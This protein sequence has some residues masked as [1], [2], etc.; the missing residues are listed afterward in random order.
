MAEKNPG[1]SRGELERSLGL[2]EALTIGV[3]TMIGA[4]IFIFPGIASG[5]A[6]LAATLSFGLGGLIS[7]VVAMCTSELA[8]GIPRSGGTYYFI[9]E[10]VGKLPG[11]IVGVGLW[12][13]LVFA[14]AFYLVG[15]GLYINQIFA[16]LGVGIQ[17]NAKALG[18]AATI[19]LVAVNVVG[20][21]KSGELQD[22]I[23]VVL[24]GLLSVILSYGALD[25]TGVLGEA[26][27]PATFAPHGVFPIFETSALV[28]TSYLGFAQIANVAGEV[29]E[30][31][32]NLPRAMIGSV[33]I[34]ALLYVLTIFVA[35]STVGA[36]R[37]GEL[38]ETAMVEV[39]RA[40]WAG[41]GAVIV[42]VGGLLATLSSANASILS[43][44]RSVYALSSDEVL[45][46]QASHLSE[47]FG[48]PVT[49]ILMVGV[50]VVALI[51]FGKVETLAEVASFLHLIL[52]GLMCAAVILLRRADPDWYDPAFR[53]PGYPVLPLVGALASFGL[54]LFMEP[55]SQVMGAGVI[56]A[57]TIW[58]FIYV[59]LEVTP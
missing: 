33:V 58:Y 56:A 11:V 48:T 18:V 31:G 43:S 42:L 7:I 17:L 57:A 20:T 15:F 34:V 28:F 10:G 3:G 54:I 21:E 40:L 6:G 55:L 1:V 24:V 46:E 27:I 25:A 5:Q 51:L 22:V 52:Y 49:S 2:K 14:S 38:G 23:V 50:P 30:P 39:G 19:G 16:E 41:V 59:K 32:K 12:W 47:R 44:S 53:T 26:T 8:T 35:T 13:G 29:T 36:E 9:S 45:P 37:L 4:G